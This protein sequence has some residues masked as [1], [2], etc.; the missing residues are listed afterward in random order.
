[1]KM[2]TLKLEELVRPDKNVRIHTEKQL[3][4]FEKS[5]N[6][7]GQ[8]RPIV[9]D[10]NN[11]IL[12]GNGLYETLVRMG[13]KEADCYQY[14]GL[15]ENQKKKL[16]IADNKIFS[17]GIE[18]L[19]T[20]NDFLVDLQGDLEIPGFDEEILRQM[21]SDADEVTE[22]ISEYGTLD[23]DEI[24]SIRESNEKR[25]QKAAENSVSSPV[26]NIINTVQEQATQ[27]PEKE[28]AENEPSTE[29]QRFIVCPKCGEKVWL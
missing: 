5:I 16:M 1:M 13:R 19:D 21:V 15:T 24:K 25:E 11:V 29:V 20:L 8:I 18:N 28:L 6:M 12:V 26:G 27:E 9:I 7:F 3:T 10:E 2:V 4:E 22:K 17:L 14:T 23:E